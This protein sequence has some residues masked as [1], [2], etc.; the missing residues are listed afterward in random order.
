MA[1]G[2][3]VVV[4]ERCGCAPDLVVNG[5]TGYAFDPLDVEALKGLLGKVSGMSG[6]AR[7]AMGA[8]GCRLIKAWGPERFGEGLS[9]A[10]EKALRVGPKRAGVLDRALLNVLCCR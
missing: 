9:A 6:E 4:S 10:A 1:C 8:A 3:P 2:L 5:E 7:A